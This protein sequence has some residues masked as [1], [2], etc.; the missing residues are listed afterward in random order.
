M[1]K[2]SKKIN[3]CPAAKA[4]LGHSDYCPHS[5]HYTPEIAA[6]EERCRD[7]EWFNDPFNPSD[8]KFATATKEEQ[9]MMLKKMLFN[10][11][12]EK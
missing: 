5:E 3:C 2:E 8:R 10:I 7:E 1:S 6:I 4:H 12:K 9:D 11:L